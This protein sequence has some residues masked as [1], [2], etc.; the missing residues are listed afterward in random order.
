MS[1]RAHG[2]PIGDVAWSVGVT[3]QTL[4]AW[5]R[6]NLIKPL[7]SKGGTRYYT[8]EDVKRLHSIKQLREMDGLNFAAIRRDL[9]WAESPEGANGFN[10]SHPTAEVGERL[11]RLRLRHRKTLK[12]VAE[13]TGLSVSFVSAVERGDS[14]AS[15][16]SL[17]ALTNLYE[18][19]WREIFDVE[20]V[21]KSR[22]IEPDN[23]VRVQ[24]PNGV[25]SEDLA[26]SG[27]LMEPTIM[28]FP[29]HTGSGE[30]FAHTGEEFIYTLSG[31]LFVSLREQAGH[32]TYQLTTGGC[33]YFP[34][35]VPHK[36]WTEDEEAQVMYVNSP[37]SF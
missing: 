21:S 23:R 10:Q 37:P 19:D 3:P 29:P 13:A 35:T 6:E 24:W 11:R 32:E 4:R 5:E 2:I 25:S 15:I 27:S 14:G 30:H 7:R 34:S 18:V 12:A 1:S 22:L 28:T 20:P 17:R 33:L 9:D 36:W 16:A 8:R 26:T 31:T